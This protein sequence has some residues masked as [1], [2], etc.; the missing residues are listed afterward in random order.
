MKIAFAIA[1]FPRYFDIK[2]FYEPAR[3]NIL[4]VYDTK[5]FAAVYEPHAER[6]YE[7]TVWI[8]DKH[9]YFR[10]EFLDELG[11]LYGPVGA[12][13]SRAF[14]DELPR[15]LR[16]SDDLP[17]STGRQ[18]AHRALYSQCAMLALTGE[19]IKPVVGEYDLVIRYRTDTMIRGCGVTSQMMQEMSEATNTIFVASSNGMGWPV[20]PDGE[21][22]SWGGMRGLC[23]AM[24]ICRPEIHLKAVSMFHHLREITRELGTIR[25]ELVFRRHIERLGIQTK[26]FPIDL[27]FPDPDDVFL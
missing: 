26:I 11:R 5:L 23:D 16:E 7:R 27:H 19:M 2:E 10:K 25:A 9:S 21:V 4:D 13:E 15:L 3:K 8:Y 24:W 14:L 18:Y 1:G 12:M 6:E 22:G 20:A 17:R